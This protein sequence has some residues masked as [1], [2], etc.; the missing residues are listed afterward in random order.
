VFYLEFLRFQATFAI[1][2]VA[3]LG[4]LFQ[5]REI[6][7]GVV[8]EIGR[9]V[10]ARMHGDRL[11]TADDLTPV[12]ISGGIGAGYWL[13]GARAPRPIDWQVYG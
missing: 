12:D 6:M 2:Q 8:D 7:Q 5:Q 11:I 10:A 3:R 4:L 13:R 9:L 1:P